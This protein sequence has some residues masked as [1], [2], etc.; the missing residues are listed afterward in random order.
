MTSLADHEA[1]IERGLKTFV[2]VGQA[3][4]AIRD[5]RLY[6]EQY[7]RFEDY[8]KEWWGWDKRYC[9]RIIGAAEV[10]IALGP[11][12]PASERVARPLTKLPEEEQADAWE[13][14]VTDSESTGEKITA[15]KVEQVVVAPTIGHSFRAPDRVRST[16]RRLS[17]G[18]GLF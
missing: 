18:M 8:C 1:T 9:N 5:G 11:T 17:I 15:K 10:K 14:V 16:D 4:Q 13:E 7:D 6:R 3:L 12:G 2:E